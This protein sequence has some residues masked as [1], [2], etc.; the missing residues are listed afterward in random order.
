MFLASIVSLLP[1]LAPWPR[2]S[3][4]WV[5]CRCVGEN[6]NGDDGSEHDEIQHLSRLRRACRPEA[7]DR[8]R[9]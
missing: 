8:V 4:R 2:P 3:E 7:Q 5:Q 1:H 9:R 6:A